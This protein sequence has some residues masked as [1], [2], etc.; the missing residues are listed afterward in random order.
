VLIPDNSH[1]KPSSTE[2][3]KIKPNDRPLYCKDSII[4]GD[5]V[6]VGEKTVILS[7]VNVGDG[8]IIGANAV[9]THDVPPYSIAVGCPAKIL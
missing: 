7:G 5:N 9:V 6:W 2:Q 4:I 8:A 1:G 3:S